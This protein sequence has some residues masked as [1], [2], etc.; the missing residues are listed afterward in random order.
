MTMNDGGTLLYMS[1]EAISRGAPEPAFDLWS[2]ALVLYEALAGQNPFE[3]ENAETTRRAIL[4]AD[5]PD[6]RDLRPDC[7][8]LIA[9]FFR[10]ELSRN[11]LDRAQTGKQFRFRMR[12]VEKELRRLAGY[13]EDSMK[14]T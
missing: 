9:G 6:I 8:P 4:D 5:L 14:K 11:A 1:P 3:R 2:L 13:A 7:P 10:C 12:A